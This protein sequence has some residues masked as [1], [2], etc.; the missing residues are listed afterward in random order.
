MYTSKVVSQRGKEL[1]CMKVRR[2]QVD[3]KDPF[4]PQWTGERNLDLLHSKDNT[5]SK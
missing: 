3:P 2:V 4:C 1:I 5:G